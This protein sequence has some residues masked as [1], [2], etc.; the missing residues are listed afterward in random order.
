MFNPS[1][2]YVTLGI[3]IPHKRMWY[4]QRN[5][6]VFLKIT[7]SDSIREYNMLCIAFLWTPI[8]LDS[9]CSCFIRCGCCFVGWPYHLS[10]IWVM[11]WFL[12]FDHDIPRLL[13]FY[14]F[15]LFMGL[16]WVAEKKGYNLWYPFY[17]WRLSG[18]GN[19]YKKLL[20]TKR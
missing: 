1:K 12:F 16:A 8:D 14:R 20:L 5:L 15:F 3:L 11:L 4:D 2:C 7:L 13:I 17:N 18:D 9:F 19:Y 6:S 10:N